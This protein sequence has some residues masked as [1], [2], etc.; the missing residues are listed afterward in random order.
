MLCSFPGGNSVRTELRE[1]R[2]ECVML[3]GLWGVP[4]SP[5]TP[6]E[7]PCPA[8]LCRLSLRNWPLSPSLC[9]YP[10][11]IVGT[12]DSHA[13]FAGALTLTGPAGS[14]GCGP[15]SLRRTT[16]T[17]RQSAQA[18]PRPRAASLGASPGGSDSGMCTG[19]L[20]GY[21]LAGSDRAGEEEVGR[22]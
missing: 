20:K 3:R 16:C 11:S 15:T 9:C 18:R 21:C 13:G 2:S 10:G 8:L 22:K 6:A 5:V 19:Q 12:G 4:G 14:G 17:A 1:Q 7:L